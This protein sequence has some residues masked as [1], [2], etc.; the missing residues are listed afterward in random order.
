MCQA[1]GLWH[2]AELSPRAGGIY[3]VNHSE[4]AARVT[5]VLARAEDKT[6]SEATELFDELC[7]EI[8]AQLGQCVGNW[9]LTQVLS[10]HAEHLQDRGE[11]GAARRVAKRH[12]EIVQ[13]EI[14]RYS[15]T[16]FCHLMELALMEFRANR[17]DA[18]IAAARQGFDKHSAFVTPGTVVGLVLEEWRKHLR[19]R[20]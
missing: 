19:C 16:A 7:R 6:T 15:E 17:P 5:E 12:L 8:E 9:H 14:R 4:W 20:R 13:R 10:L 18:G 1:E 11:V 3:G 2:L